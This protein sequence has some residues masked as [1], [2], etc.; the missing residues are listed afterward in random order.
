MLH[1]F[2]LDSVID[3]AAPVILRGDEFHHAVRVRRVRPGELVEVF[4]PLGTSYEAIVETIDEDAVTLRISRPIPSRES[5]LRITLA[6]ALIQPDRFELV[7]Q[8]ATELGVSRIIPVVSERTEVRLERVEKKMDR[9]ARIVVEAVKQCG[10]ATAP[11][12]DSPT[13]FDDVIGSPGP[14]FILDAD[15]DSA[16]PDAPLDEVTMLIGPEGGFSEGEMN[17]AIA[18]GCRG[19][20][21]GPRRLRAETAAM[22]AMVLAQTKWGDMRQR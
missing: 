12:L 22:A 19:L 11:V 7:L 2:S 14:R 18:A 3:P 1:R 16:D 15:A 21:L 4:D 6:L 5:P 17:R 13:R 20:G 9:W 8:K 10:R